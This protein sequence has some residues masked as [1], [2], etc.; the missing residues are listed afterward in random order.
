MKK[1]S[2]RLENYNGLFIAHLSIKG[3]SEWTSKKSA[4]NHAIK[5]AEKNLHLNVIVEAF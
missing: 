4:Y 1:Y 5:Y 3:K 2:I